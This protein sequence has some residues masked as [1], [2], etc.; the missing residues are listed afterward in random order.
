MKT[1]RYWTI[2]IETKNENGTTQGVYRRLVADT[3]AQ[4]LAALS[5]EERANVTYLSGEEVEYVQ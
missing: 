3:M 2:R 4:V 5:D 1:T